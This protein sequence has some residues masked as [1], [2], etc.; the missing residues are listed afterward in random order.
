VVAALAMGADAVLSGRPLVYGLAVDGERGVAAVLD[1]LRT[2]VESV[3]AH[4]GARTIADLDA[5]L[6]APG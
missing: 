5:D 6:I 4:C 2:E 1:E 3:M